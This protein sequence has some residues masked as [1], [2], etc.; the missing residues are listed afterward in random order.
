MKRF[1]ISTLKNSF[2]PS[3]FRLR[4]RRGCFRVQKRPSFN[5]YP[6]DSLSCVSPH[7]LLR[8]EVCKPKTLNNE[9]SNLSCLRSILAS[10]SSMQLKEK[11]AKQR[12][13][14]T[15]TA[16]AAAL[17]GRLFQVSSLEVF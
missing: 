16:E 14:N 11:Q 15:K 17:F 13:N 9:L 1:A 8:H 10:A 7:A 6:Q 2:Q 4:A 5:V 12:S 3:F